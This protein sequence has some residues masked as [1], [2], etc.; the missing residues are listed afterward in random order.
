M[1]VSIL[2]QA[3]IQ[4]DKGEIRVPSKANNGSG[5]L[6]HLLGTSLV[7]RLFTTRTPFDTNSGEFH[8][9][10]NSLALPNETMLFRSPV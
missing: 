6:E 9:T 10:V 8:E 1:K 4:G 5:I 2:L 7:F 3:G